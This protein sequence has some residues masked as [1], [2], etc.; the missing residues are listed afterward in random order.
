MIGR[1]LAALL[2]FMMA[3]SE[4]P[5]LELTGNPIQGGLI[6]GKVEPG[7]SVRL[8]DQDLRVSDDG[9]FVFGIGRDAGDALELVWRSPDGA[10]GTETLAVKK[11]DWKISRINGLP[12]RMVAPGP[13]D[14]LR[15]QKDNR[16][17][18]A[19]RTLDTEATDFLQTFR[20]PV[21]GRISGVFGSQRILNGKPKHFHNGVDIAAPVGALVQA[22][23]SGRVVLVRQDMF[24]SGKTVMLDH[25]H[26]VTSVYIHMSEIL[27][28]EGR[29]IEQGA[30]LGRVGMTGRATGPHLHWG[31]SWFRTHVDPALLAG[32]MP[33]AK[34]N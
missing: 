28:S 14:L 8:A 23:A 18:G 19:V 21:P 9:R 1:L 26:G 2:I 6:I 32:P 7:T 22:P 5:A 31:V 16:A 10:S 27:V 15:I 17:I 24:Y 3:R 4:A 33:G 25:G 30:P 34:T 13:E 20:W 29:R 11:R 12:K